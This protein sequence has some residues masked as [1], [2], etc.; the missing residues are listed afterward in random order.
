MENIKLCKNCKHCT[1]YI[2][3]TGIVLWNISTC[4]R[5]NR[6]IVIDLVGGEE[7]KTHCSAQRYQDWVD[8]CGPDGKYFEAK[9]A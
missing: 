8:S 2:G 4:N 1:P 5:P 6:K 3:A 9:E 7:E